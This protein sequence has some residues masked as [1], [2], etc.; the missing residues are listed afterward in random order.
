MSKL[1]S[2]INNL[3][4]T[5]DRQKYISKLEQN[6]GFK[7]ISR[8][9][10]H[11]KIMDKYE[12]ITSKIPKRNIFIFLSLFII[13]LV[14]LYYFKPKFILKNID[15]TSENKFKINS[16]KIPNEKAVRSEEHLV[17]Y[18]KLIFYSLIVSIILFCVLYFTRNKVRY[19]GK[20]FENEEQ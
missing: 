13:T 1:N 10:I 16:N 7:G 17:S 20:I 19:I 12:D 15:K 9:P 18:W 5:A 3:I 11:H 4:K 6:I 2:P 14:I 8:T